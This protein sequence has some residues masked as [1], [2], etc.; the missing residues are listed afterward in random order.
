MPTSVRADPVDRVNAAH[1]NPYGGKVNSRKGQKG[2]KAYGIETWPADA[3]VRPLANTEAAK[4]LKHRTSAVDD[5]AD[6]FE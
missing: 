1:A 3:P 2:G 5:A 4:Y 6:D